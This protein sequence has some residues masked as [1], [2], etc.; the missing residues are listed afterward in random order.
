M[1]N[2]SPDYP[3]VEPFIV[4]VWYG[5]GKPSPVNEFLSAFVLELNDLIENGIIVNDHKLGI[6]VRCFICDTP[7]R[8]L[9]KGKFQSIVCVAQFEQF[10]V[11]ISIYL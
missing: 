11:I 6:K 5:D 1:N 9:L 7:A 8:S 3:A 2:F 10:S 4:S